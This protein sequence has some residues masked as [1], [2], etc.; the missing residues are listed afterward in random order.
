[1]AEF[2]PGVSPL[3]RDVYRVAGEDRHLNP[4]TRG[5]RWVGTLVAGVLDVGDAPALSDIVITRVQDDGEAR[6]IRESSVVEFE[7]TMRA[8]ASDL[9]TLTPE[10][11]A[12]VWLRA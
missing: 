5:V 8:V 2:A 6:R 7:K 3:A 12:E 9:E 11:F 1:M 4:V 10:A